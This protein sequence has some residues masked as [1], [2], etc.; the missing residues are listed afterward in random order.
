LV[1]LDWLEEHAWKDCAYCSPHF[2]IKGPQVLYCPIS[3]PCPP[4]LGACASTLDL[5]G[6]FNGS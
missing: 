2:H 3:R 6:P 4:S 5:T 1:G